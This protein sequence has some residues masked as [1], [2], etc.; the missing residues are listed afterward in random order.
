MP[1]NKYQ[2]TKNKMGKIADA[3]GITIAVTA[4]VGLFL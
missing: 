4:I 1:Q 3:I 2:L